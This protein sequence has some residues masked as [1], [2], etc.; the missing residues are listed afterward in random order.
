[1]KAIKFECSQ[2]I[3]LSFVFLVLMN[4]L[5]SCGEISAKWKPQIEKISDT[6]IKTQTKFDTLFKDFKLIEFKKVQDSQIKI[7]DTSLSRKCLNWQLS[8]NQ[9]VSILKNAEYTEYN[10]T[11]YHY[12]LICPCSYS[13]KVKFHDSIYDFQISATGTGIFFNNEREYK[14][15]NNGKT[16]IKSYFIDSIRHN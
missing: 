10:E 5:V 2:I 14:F 13:G 6:S 9:I 12:Y 7:N 3:Y 11:Y 8:P 1:M 15:F 4:S 16:F